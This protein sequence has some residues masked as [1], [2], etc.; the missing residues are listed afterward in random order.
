MAIFFR[1]YTYPVVHLFINQFGEYSCELKEYG[2]QFRSNYIVYF[3]INLV[4]FG[5]EDMS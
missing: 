2:C 1:G 3:N 5:L 4:M